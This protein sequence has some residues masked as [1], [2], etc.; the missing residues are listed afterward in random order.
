MGGHYMGD[1]IRKYASGEETLNIHRLIR[2][3]YYH[4]GFTA[5]EI[6]EECRKQAALIDILKKPEPEKELRLRKLVAL[7]MDLKALGLIE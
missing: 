3:Q 5:E 7:I 1:S 4:E 6:I 2:N